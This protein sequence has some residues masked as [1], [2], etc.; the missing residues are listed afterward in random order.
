MTGEV[1]TINYLAEPLLHHGGI[2]IIVVGPFFVAGVVWRINVYALDFPG[3][4]WKQRLE[5]LQVVSVDDEIVMK[6]DLVGQTLVLFRNQLMVFDE[7]MV[8]LNE[9]F[10]FKLNLRHRFTPFVRPTHFYKESKFIPNLNSLL[11]LKS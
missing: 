5:G 10:A 9:R 2:D 1:F 6:T 11:H 3:I 7:Q 4:E 8:I